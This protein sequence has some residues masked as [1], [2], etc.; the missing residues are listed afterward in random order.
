MNVDLFL[1]EFSAT[2]FISWKCYVDNSTNGRLDMI[3]GRDLLTALVM[4]IKYYENIVIYGEVP[5]EGCSSPMVDVSNYDFK[6]LTKNR[7]NR[8]NPFLTHGS[9]NYSDP[10]AP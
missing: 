6:P 5:Y 10:R 8:K 7:F 3:Q 1:P 2:K 9:N 4:D